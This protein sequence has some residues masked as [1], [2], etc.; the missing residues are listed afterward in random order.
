MDIHILFS[1][2]FIC[3][4]IRIFI[5][6]RG[7]GTKKGVSALS[8]TV[9]GLEFILLYTYNIGSEEIDL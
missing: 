2:A 3:I 7:K 5:K 4:Y 6:R 1:Y 8:I 9:F